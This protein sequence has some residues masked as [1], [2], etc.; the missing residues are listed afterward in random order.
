MITD[1]LRS[2]LCWIFGH[3]PD[4]FPHGICHCLRCG[5]GPLFIEEDWAFDLFED[6][7]L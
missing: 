4:G 7:I 5:E 3:E 1:L 6:D 2:T